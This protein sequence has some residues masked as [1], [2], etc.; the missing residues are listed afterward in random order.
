M[1]VT[2]KNP[3]NGYVESSSVPFLWNFLFGSF[4]YAYKGVWSHFFI[5]WAVAICTLGL[6]WFV[7]PFFA[8]GIIIK[9]YN[10][11]GWEQLNV[12]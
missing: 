5:S 12:V 9:R 6:S 7:Y 3:D 8:K 11:R 1:A 10:Q 2:F 4:Y